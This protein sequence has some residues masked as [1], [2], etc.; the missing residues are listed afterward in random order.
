MVCTC[1]MKAALQIANCAWT[2]SWDCGRVHLCV[3]ASPNQLRQGQVGLFVQQ[4]LGQAALGLAIVQHLVVD[5]SEA[6]SPLVVLCVRVCHLRT[7]CQAC[8]LVVV[9]AATEECA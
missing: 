3:A 4:C 9:H 1:D 7:W 6:G 2:H 8:T 5:S